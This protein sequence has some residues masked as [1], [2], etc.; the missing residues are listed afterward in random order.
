MA[1]GLAGARPTTQRQ[2]L[3]LVVMPGPFAHLVE[4]LPLRISQNLLDLSAHLAAL[5]DHVRH[6]LAALLRQG[7]YSTAVAVAAAGQLF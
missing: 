3:S 1:G 5:N 2:L 7:C 6:Q 4:L